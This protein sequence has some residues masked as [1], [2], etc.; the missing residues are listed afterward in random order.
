MTTAVLTMVFL[1]AHKT[2]HRDASKTQGLRSK[3]G[4]ASE[5]TFVP[6]SR[7][8]FYCKA[9]MLVYKM[10]YNLHIALFRWG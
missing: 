3:V 5:V 10:L 8:R 7:P 1:L 4:N 9:L 6:T 2:A